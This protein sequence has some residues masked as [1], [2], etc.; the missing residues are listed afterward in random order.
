MCSKKIHRIKRFW[1]RTHYKCSLQMVYRSTV[2]LSTGTN[3]QVVYARLSSVDI[4][5]L[6]LDHQSAASFSIGTI[7]SLCTN[8]QIVYAQPS[9]VI[10]Y[11]LQI[12]YKLAN[13]F[14]NGTDL[15]LN[16]TNREIA[17]AR[18]SSSL[19]MVYQWIEEP[20]IH[21]S[22]TNRKAF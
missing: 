6:Q 17:Y 4:C 20:S 7:G 10:I 5:S 21:T 11:S 13:Y 16:G 18:L 12:V 15:N 9:G 22:G 1:A 2:Y 3:R 19:Q 8:R 14:S